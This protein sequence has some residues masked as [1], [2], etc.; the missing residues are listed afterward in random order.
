MSNPDI[1]NQYIKNLITNKDRFMI[2]RTGWGA[3]PVISYGIVYNKP[4][5]LRKNIRDILE[6]NAGIYNQ[7]S[8][9]L[10]KWG[11][12]Y[13]NAIKNS[14][15]CFVWK[16]EKVSTIIKQAQIML[17]YGVN[18]MSAEHLDPLV[19]VNAGKI[20][21]TQSLREKKIL[22]ISPFTDSIKYQ[23]DKGYNL[24]SG[25][26][27]LFHPDQKYIYYKTF[28]T[29]GGNFVHSNWS[30]TFMKMIQDISILDFDI[31][32]V[33]C[34]GYGLPICDFIY[35]R[36][37]KSSIYVGGVLPLLFG[38]TCQRYKDKDKNYN[39]GMIKPNANEQ[40]EMKSFQQIY[41][42]SST[43]EVENKC[44]W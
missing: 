31:A 12:L 23:N 35:T 1:A 9:N 26:N 25:D 13:H 24:V 33:S 28:N 32:L 10:R 43:N 44:Y 21:W 40:V 8:E 34:G 5:F 27:R 16:N 17:T 19:A 38:V 41:G 39:P 6:Y 2:T 15:C 3:E 42:Y 20:P 22:I 14:T 36:I 18:N 11:Y 29:L 4:Q 7:N 30:E 37:K